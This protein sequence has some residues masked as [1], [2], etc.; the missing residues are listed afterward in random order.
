MLLKSVILVIL[1]ATCI[2]GFV[3]LADYSSRPGPEANVPTTMPG[4]ELSQ[5][6]LREGGPPAIILFYHP[7]CPCTFAT[8]RCLERLMPRLGCA[9]RVHAF[10]YCPAGEPDSWIESRTTK[11]LRNMSETVIYVD[12]GGQK[13]RQFDVAISGHVLVYDVKGNLTFSGGL[14]PYRGHEGDSAAALGF[15]RTINNRG[16]A[17]ERSSWPVFG[18]PIVESTERGRNER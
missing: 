3:K 17:Q 8:A 7:H 4:D 13:C 6:S 12:R 18:C 5:F 9:P 2:A 10:A 16:G 15:V 1:L 11:I 14:T